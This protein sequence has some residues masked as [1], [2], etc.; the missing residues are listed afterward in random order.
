MERRY[1][2]GSLRLYFGIVIVIRGKSRRRG[3]KGKIE[4]I[5]IFIKGVGYIFI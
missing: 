5:N 2:E 1:L 4:L 3:I